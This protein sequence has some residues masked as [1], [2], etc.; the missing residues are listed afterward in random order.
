ML[1]Q[2]AGREQ[3]L[4]ATC[5]TLFQNMSRLSAVLIDGALCPAVF[6]RKAR[7]PQVS[8]TNPSKNAVTKAERSG[9]PLPS[10]NTE[11]ARSVLASRMSVNCRLGILN[12]SDEN[13]LGY[14]P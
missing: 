9:S 12:S 2:T 7:A 13:A 8:R 11:L 10:M 14:W 1:C 4:R 5:R 6:G 3:A